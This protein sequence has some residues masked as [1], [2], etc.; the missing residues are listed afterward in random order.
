MP[1]EMAAILTK[2]EAQQVLNSSDFDTMVA[3]GLAQAKAGQGRP[4]V[5]VKNDLKKKMK[6]WR[7]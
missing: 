1:K 4:V 6:E 2:D 3:A 7:Q 5:D